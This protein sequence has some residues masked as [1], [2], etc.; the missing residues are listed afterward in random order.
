MNSRLLLICLLFN[1]ISVS[2]FPQ[3]AR[4][5]DILIDEILPDPT[6]PQ[7]LPNSEFVELK[8]MS[9]VPYHLLNWKIQDATTSAVIKTDFILQPD[10][11]V[12]ICPTSSLDEYGA[13]GSAIGVSKLPSLN[14]DGDTI[15]ISSP[16]G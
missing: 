15:W 3:T 5:H 13:F 9:A 11:F 1:G 4:P 2:L 7:G 14:N 8:N 6:P 10:S 12:V 16:E